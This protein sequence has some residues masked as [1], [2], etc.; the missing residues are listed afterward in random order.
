MRVLAAVSNAAVNMGVR[1]SLLDS[2]LVVLKYISSS[3]IAGSY[4]RS[5]FNFL[6]KSILEIQRSTKKE[7]AEGNKKKLRERKKSMEK[8]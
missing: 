3:G 4:G 1:I 7:K 2:A 5:I 6:R 8:R